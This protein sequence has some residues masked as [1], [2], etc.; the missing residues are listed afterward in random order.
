MRITSS[1]IYVKWIG[2][3]ILRVIHTD[4][5]VSHRKK[6]K[7]GI[8]IWETSWAIWG[9]WTNE[10]TALAIFWELSAKR[11]AVYLGIL[12]EDF[13]LQRKCWLYKPHMTHGFKEC[14]MP[15]EIDNLS[16]F[17]CKTSACQVVSKR[18]K[19]V[20]TWQPMCRHPS[21]NACCKLHVADLT[22]QGY[23]VFLN[24]RR[25]FNSCSWM[26]MLALMSNIWFMK[27]TLDSLL[28]VNW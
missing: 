25:Y 11:P 18:D 24:H 8:Q 27:S 4:L 26:A 2:N 14:L 13:L 21:Y 17:I 3:F 15:L 19:L 6:N 1:I 12:R 20:T 9:D 7:K 16:S 5:D 10:Y 22:H 28:S 23:W